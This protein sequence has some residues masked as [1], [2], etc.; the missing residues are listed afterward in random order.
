MADHMGRVVPPAD[1]AKALEALTQDGI[2]DIEKRAQSA[3]QNAML[4]EIVRTL[5]QARLN[6]HY[7]QGMCGRNYSQ[8]C[9]F[10]W[11]QQGFPDG[12]IGCTSGQ[13]SEGLPMACYQYNV[14]ESLNAPAKAN[15]ALSCKVQW[16]CSACTRDFS[17][18]P[19][20]FVPVSPSEPGHCMPKTE[21]VGPCTGTIDFRPIT[22]NADKARWA[23]RCLTKW[24]C[25]PE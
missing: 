17:N 15:F 23:A 24:P 20:H 5:V 13:P 8:P 10:G 14:T 19:Q 7:Y 2:D 11:T 1:N 25:H 9:P 18:C 6:T 12:V 16:P 3:D 4:G 21:Y 22:D